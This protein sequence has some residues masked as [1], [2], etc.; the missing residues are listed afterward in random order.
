MSKK[1]ILDVDAS[2]G[3]INIKLP[4]GNAKEYEF[5]IKKK[6]SSSNV[7]TTEGPDTETWDMGRQEDDDK[8][9]VE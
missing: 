8:W 5:I 9:G 4:S 3:D 2:D 7:I 6:D 1:I